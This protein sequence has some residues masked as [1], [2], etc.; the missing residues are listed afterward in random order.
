MPIILLWHL[1]QSFPSCAVIGPQ[2][3]EELNSSIQA[4]DIQLTS[5]EK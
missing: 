1:N 4:L 3:V 2:K 5:E